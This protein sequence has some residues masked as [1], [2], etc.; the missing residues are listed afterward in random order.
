VFSP[1]ACGN[2]FDIVEGRS[3][4]SS[5]NEFVQKHPAF[6]AFRKEQARITDRKR[7]CLLMDHPEAF[8]RIYRA[9]GCRPA[10]NM[11]D[12][13]LDGHIAHHLDEVADQWRQTAEHLRP[14]MPGERS[15]G[16]RQRRT[17]SSAAA[18]GK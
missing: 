2:I 15:I 8:R 6:R 17:A 9:G 7:P 4:Y 16:M 3:E 11:P 10:R 18:G 12:G 13:Y 1:V 5:L 14:L